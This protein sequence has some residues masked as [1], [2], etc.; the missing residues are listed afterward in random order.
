MPLTSTLR[1]N[2]TGAGDDP[3]E[4][5]RRYQ[6]ALDMAAY[7]DAHGFDAVGLEEHHCAAN[8]WLPSPLV[9]AGMIVARTERIPVNV[10]ALLITLYDPI[11]LAEDIAVLDLASAGRFNFIAGMG[12]RPIEYHALDKGW[13]DRGARMDETL[14]ALLKAWEGKPFEYR[15]K[16]VQVTPVPLSRPHP[17]MFIGGM[18]RAAARRAARFGLPLFPPMH[19]PEL[20]AYY[21]EE[22]ERQGKGG[23][24]LSFATNPEQA[25]S[26]LFIDPD[27]E[28]AWEELS[29]HFLHELQ[30]YASWKVDG[31]PRPQEEDAASVEQLRAQKR[32][33]ILTPGECLQR[34][35]DQ[36][37]YSAVLH[38][39]AGGVP[40][41][42]AWQCLH[43][44]VEEVLQ[45]LRELQTS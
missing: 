36:Q 26:M 13:D 18:S 25:S 16:T 45:P 42:R 7:V 10:T 37:D 43:L 5:S 12:Y 27:P 29:P 14:E 8:G 28:R 2:M 23:T 11:R 32:F 40:V 34:F 44:Y 4:E 17:P 20:E 31:V 9:M 33:E 15:G 19:M 6:Q 38:P 22:V 21:Y 35:R 24:V 41:E 1:I 30:E 3:R 39:L